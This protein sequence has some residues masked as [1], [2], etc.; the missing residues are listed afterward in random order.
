MLNLTLRPKDDRHYY[1]WKNIFNQVSKNRY[2]ERV[3]FNAQPD[4][5]ND[6]E[7]YY[8]SRTTYNTQLTGRYTFTKDQI[9]W[10]AGYAYA[11]RNLPDR[12][13]I[14]RTDRTEQRMGIYRISREF[15]RLDEHILSAGG[16]YRRDFSFGSFEPTL[17][18]G[19]YGEYRTRTYNVRQ[20]QY[21]WQP[22]NNLP[23]GF[24]FWEDVQGR[25][26]QDE[27]YGPD[28]LYLYEEVNFLNNYK[29]EQTQLAGYIGINFP[30]GAFNIYAGVRYEYNRQVLKMNTRQYEESLQSTA[31]N[32]NDLFPSLNVI[33]KLS[34]KH[35]LRAAYGRSVNRPEFRELSTSVYYDFELGSS[36]MGNYDLKSAYIDNFDLRYEWYPTTGEQ[37][38]LALFY[39]HFKNPIEWTYTVA[40]GTDLIYSFMNARGANNYGVE[41]DIRKNLDFIGMKNFSLSFNGSWIESKVQFEPGSNNIDRPMQGQSPYLINAGIFYNNLERGWNAAVLYNRVGK[42]IIGVGNRYGTGAD[43][44]SRNIPNSYEMPRNSL[45][46][47]VGKKIGHLELKLSVRDILAERCLFK[48]FEDVTING[49]QRT[50]EEVTRSWKPGRNFTLTIGY[51]F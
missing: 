40:G 39:K 34:E 10:S 14:E 26:L 23:A 21:G 43:G 38:S 1:E 4:N 5:I 22:Q 25:L 13:L 7:Y 36:V 47:S 37:I 46:L 8:S 49:Q 51:S 17:K 35:Q 28:K 2:A 19:I 16:N 48:Q 42:R 18:A 6:M 41:L 24:L 45:D 30:I 12:R 32:N 27:N 33:Y 15:T 20:F 11:N 3:G 31:Y 50:I 9:D 44:S 29:G